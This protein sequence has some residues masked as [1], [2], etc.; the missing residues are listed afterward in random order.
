MDRYW[1][2]SG[3]TA[4]PVV[5]SSNAGGF[6]ADGNPSVGIAGTVPGAWWYYAITEELRNA[7]IKLGGVPDWTKIDQLG[8]AISA[9]ITTAINSVTSEL[10]K[11]AYTGSYTDLSNKPTIPPAY[12]LAPATTTTLGGIVAGP[13]TSIA[14]DGTLTAIGKVKT[15]NTNAPD[16]QGNV[17]ALIQDAKGIVPGTSASMIQFQGGTGNPLMRVIQCHG[18][19]TYTDWNGQMIEIDTVPATD[20]S[21]GTV[22]AGAGLSVAADGT[23][24]AK[25]TAIVNLTGGAS[26][27]LDLKPIAQGAP[28]IL[29]NLAIGNGVTTAVSIANAPITG[30][31][32][33]F[34]LQVTNGAGSAITWPYNM[35]WPQG[36]A[37]SLSGVAGKLDTFVIFTQNGGATYNAFVA[38]QNQ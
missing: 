6:P 4:A 33:Q 17:S 25:D 3:V 32:A 21:L 22:I 16:S 12:A 13:G 18:I 38:G 24:A 11:V 20:S 34:V 8:A 2:S 23:L 37:P 36:F 15:V 27:A 29:F 28:E 14:A 19:G 9:S 30:T 31:L 26:V 1:K 35:L 5:P 7:I 10:A